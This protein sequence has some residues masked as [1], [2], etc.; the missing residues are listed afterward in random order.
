[1]PFDSKNE[2]D[3]KYGEPGYG[4][5]EP[6]WNALTKS[7]KETHDFLDGCDYFEAAMAAELMMAMVKAFQ[8]HEDWD[9]TADEMTKRSHVWCEYFLGLPSNT[10]SFSLLEILRHAVEHYEACQDL[11]RAEAGLPNSRTLQ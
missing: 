1:M 6:D 4:E 11:E 10:S 9:E 8:D 2:D 5:V 7:L 3:I